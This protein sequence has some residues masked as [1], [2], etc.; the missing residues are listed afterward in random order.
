MQT[1]QHQ[2]KGVA[3]YE[4]MQAVQYLSVQVI[5]EPTSHQQHNN[6]ECC[7]V[8]LVHTNKYAFLAQ[9][10]ALQKGFL[11]LSDA[12]LEELGKLPWPCVWDP[13]QTTYHSCALQS[14]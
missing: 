14:L 12:L 7:C 11:T 6:S 3:D 5:K 9:V 2:S 13:V 1:L 4:S 10:N 8:N